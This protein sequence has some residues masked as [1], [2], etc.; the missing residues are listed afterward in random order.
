MEDLVRGAPDPERRPKPAPI[1]HTRPGERPGPAAPLVP[2]AQTKPLSRRAK[3][4]LGVLAVLLGGGGLLWSA[5]QTFP[6]VRDE[7]VARTVM[8]CSASSHCVAAGPGE[9]W[10]KGS[11]ALR[12]LWNWENPAA[13]LRSGPSSACVCEADM[14]LVDSKEPLRVPGTVPAPGR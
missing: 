10:N 12:A 4:A 3:I 8:R 1:I 7:L 14:C 11:A 9:C 13:V 2:R 6:F 5:A